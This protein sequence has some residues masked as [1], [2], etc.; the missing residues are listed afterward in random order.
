MMLLYSA[1]NTRANILFA[2][3]KLAKAWSAVAKPTISG[4]LA[5]YKDAHMMPSNSAQTTLTMAWI[6][7]TS[8]NYPFY[9]HDW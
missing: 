4:S 7:T 9:P 1:Y 5:I 3:C 8:S 2:V 6:Y